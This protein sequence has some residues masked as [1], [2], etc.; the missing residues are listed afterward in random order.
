MKKLLSLFLLVPSILPAQQNNSL[1]W[2]I[3]GKG[4]AAPSYVFGTYHLITSSYI[5]S[6]PVILQSLRKTKAVIGEMVVDATMQQKVMDA[7][8]MK[9]SS[10]DQL[11]SAADYELV[12]AYFKEQ[13]GMDLGFFKKMKPVVVSTLFY[14][15]LMD[16]NKGTPM[17]V[18]FQEKGKENGEDV[19]GLETIEQ[20][21]NVLFS[22]MPLRRQAELL[23]KAVKEKDKMKRDMNQ[24]DS[25]YRRGNL[26]A[27]G[28]YMMAEDSY[29]SQEMDELLYSRNANWI[30]QLPQL[31]E[32]RPVFIAVGAGHLPG[33][34]G[35][36]NLLRQAGYT[37]S[38]VALN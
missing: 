30:K 24:M 26:D 32:K 6:F 34:K 7:S 29:S 28:K 14:K 5:D 10:L 9:D 25:C 37:V 35:L 19:I 3:S 21:M 33:Q 11:M 23:V 31:M 22:G 27:L 2:E 1:L 20:Q 36:L 4:M 16:K 15:P 8:L 18:Y 12:S 17:D 13:L 38:V